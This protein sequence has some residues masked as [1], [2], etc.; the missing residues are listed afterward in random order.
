[1]RLTCDCINIGG[2]GGY[3]LQ[4]AFQV[5]LRTHYKFLPDTQPASFFPIPL[6]DFTQHY[7]E[8]LQKNYD[9]II[10][11]QP[12]ANRSLMIQL[13]KRHNKKNTPLIRLQSGFLTNLVGQT[14]PTL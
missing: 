5:F 10:T 3:D 9:P 14:V 2:C 11:Y 4:D 1:M 13:V 7:I 8:F 6:Q 12:D